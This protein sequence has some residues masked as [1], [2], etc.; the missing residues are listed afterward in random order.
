MLAAPVDMVNR[1]KSSKQLIMK[2]FILTSYH[3]WQDF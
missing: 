3:I 1:S 2:Q